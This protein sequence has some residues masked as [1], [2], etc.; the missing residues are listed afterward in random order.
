MELTNYGVWTT[1]R[2][3]GGEEQLGEAARV[4][5]R[6]G[7]GA[8]WLGGSPRLP[9]TRALLEASERIVVATGIVNVWHYEPAQLASEY[10]QLSAD[11]PGRLLLGLGVGH[12]EATSAYKRPLAKMR[13]FL[14]GLR[15]APTP[16]PREAMCLAAL[17]PKM[18]DLA[19]ERT[20]GAHPYFTPAAHTRFARQRLGPGLLIA[21]ELA[22]VLD[23]DRERARATARRYAQGY[24]RLRNYKSNLLRHGFDDRDIAGGGSDRLLDAVVPQGDA[25]ALGSAVR[26]HLD[27][28]ADHV[29]VQT[30]GVSGVPEREWG[31]LAAV[32]L[33]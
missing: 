14:D 22:L 28:G 27:A 29:C 19:A 12:P 18:L 20:L 15:A 33:G 1:Q 25:A 16:V 26:E 3:L 10:A 21:P 4:A 2:A 31:E 30:V 5:E 23:S 24:L 13:S 32:L 9:Q 17:G 11:F 6:L 7:F 8:I